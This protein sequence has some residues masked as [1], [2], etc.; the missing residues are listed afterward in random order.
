MTAPDNTYLQEAL[1]SAEFAEEALR[2]GLASVSPVGCLV[3]MQLL[4]RAVNLR[5]GINNFLTAVDES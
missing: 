3:L 1:H 4:E 2:N 5:I